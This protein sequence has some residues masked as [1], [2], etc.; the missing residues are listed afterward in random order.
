MDKMTKISFIEHGKKTS[1][2]LDLEHMDVRR[3]IISQP[4]DGHSICD[5]V[6]SFIC[7]TNLV[8]SFWGYALEIAAYV[9]NKIPLKS[10]TS[11]PYEIWKEASCPTH[12]KRV[13]VHK[14][15]AKIDL[16]KF[17]SYLKE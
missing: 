9:L 10:V 7:F 5:M 14:F 13:D 17:I 2:V 8:I 6:C 12:V 1:K 11:T 3:L 16:Y 15:C 4:R